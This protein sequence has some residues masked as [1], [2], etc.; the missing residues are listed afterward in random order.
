[1]QDLHFKPVDKLF[2]TFDGYLIKVKDK[3]WLPVVFW[4]IFAAYD[5][6]SADFLPML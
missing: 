1:M 4:S 2:I 3:L 5:V 6:E